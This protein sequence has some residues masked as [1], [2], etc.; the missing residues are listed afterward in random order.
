MFDCPQDFRK[1][2]AVASALEAGGRGEK[3]A[4]GHASPQDR[5]RVHCILQ[6]WI[7]L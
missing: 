6:L 4:G 5:N 2:V 1:A 7:L 3:R